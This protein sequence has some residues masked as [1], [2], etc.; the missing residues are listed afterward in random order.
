MRQ[1]RVQLRAAD[2]PPA[3]DHLLELRPEAG[4]HRLPCDDHGAGL[5][6]C[7][8]RRV[9]QPPGVVGGGARH[10]HGRAENP[11]NPVHSRK[12]WGARGTTCVRR[13]RLTA[14]LKARRNPS[15]C[16]PTAPHSSQSLW[17]SNKR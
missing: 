14:L 17:L 8:D 15:I 7:G 5:Q 11:Q 6:T 4:V 10:V 12:A 1:L 16:S 9:S 13:S 2:H 3:Q